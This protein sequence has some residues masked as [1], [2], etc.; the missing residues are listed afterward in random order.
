M[1]PPRKRQ[2]NNFDMIKYPPAKTGGY[3]FLSVTF[4]LFFF[5][6]E[7]RVSLRL[8]NP[9]HSLRSYAGT[10][11]ARSPLGSNDHSG[12][13][14]LPRGRFATKE[15]LAGVLG[16]GCDI[17]PF[18]FQITKSIIYLVKN[19]CF[20]QIKIRINNRNHKFVF[21]HTVYFQINTTIIFS[22]II[23][24]IHSGISIFCN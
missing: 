10:R 22:R 11:R 23:F 24:I 14:S 6:K 7:K 2:Q 18:P 16:I 8:R 17:P 19:Q 1:L 12:R 5:I 15:N 3:F 21:F 4:A 13:Y 9:T 20:G